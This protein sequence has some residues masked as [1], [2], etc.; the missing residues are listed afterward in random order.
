MVSIH[1]HDEQLVQILQDLAARENRPVEDVLYTLLDQ[2][3][4]R[5]DLLKAMD[6]MFDDD[7][8][9]LSTSVRDTTMNYYRKRD[10]ESR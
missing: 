6:S 4:S 1:I 3:T 2:Y 8:T 9:D 10:E 5:I 7:I